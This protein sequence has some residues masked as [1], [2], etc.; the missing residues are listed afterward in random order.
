MDPPSSSSP[1]TVVRKCKWHHRKVRGKLTCSAT[2]LLMAKASC[3]WSS[4]SPLVWGRACSN[5]EDTRGDV[6][7]GSQ[8]KQS[9]HAILVPFKL[10][11]FN[12]HITSLSIILQLCLTGVNIKMSMD[13]HFPFNKWM[14]HNA[15]KKDGPKPHEGWETEGEE[16]KDI[17][18]IL[19]PPPPPPPPL[20]KSVDKIFLINLIFSFSSI[21]ETPLNTLNWCWLFH[22]KSKLKKLPEQRR[23]TQCFLLLSKWA[24]EHM[25]GAGQKDRRKNTVAITVALTPVSATHQLEATPT[26]DSS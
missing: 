18:G 12:K 20:I 24:S 4:S 6:A 5:S 11:H 10:T 17:G 1:L 25:A 22:V 7:V 8:T 23:R 16:K 13:Q 9:H 3:S 21:C 19:K 15:L 26:S 2:S 14:S